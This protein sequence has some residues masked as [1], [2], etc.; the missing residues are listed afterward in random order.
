MSAGRRGGP[1]PDDA[2]VRYCHDGSKHQFEPCG[3]FDRNLC[4]V[5][6]ECGRQLAIVLTWGGEY[7][8]EKRTLAKPQRRDNGH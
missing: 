6:P 8:H 4:E 3:M 5:C 1:L 7:H 2:D